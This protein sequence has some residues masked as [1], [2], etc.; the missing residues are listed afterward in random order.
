MSEPTPEATPA[1]ETA[2]AATTPETPTSTEQQ[3]KPTETVDFWKQKAREQEQRAKANADKAREFDAFKESQKS[4]AEKN[5]ERAAAAE[6]ER[7]ELKAEG[8]R[9]KAAAKHGISEDFFDLLGTGDEEAIGGRA[10]RIGGLLKLQSENERLTAELTALKEGKPAPG[11]SRP[12]A[13]LK[14]GASPEA[15][16]P[17]QD[18]SY[19]A[20]WLPQRQ[21]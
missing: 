10:E 14:P 12:V 18:N 6:R 7:D 2:E 13:A 9:Y 16:K 19:P 8:L 3:P 1:T 4:E 20:H 11:S 15:I 17:P 5:V 21:Q